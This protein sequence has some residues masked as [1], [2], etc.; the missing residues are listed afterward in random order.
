MLCDHDRVTDLEAVRLFRSSR[1]RDGSL[2]PPLEVGTV[3]MSFI[4]SVGI[5]RGGPQSLQN[6]T[7]VFPFPTDC[8]TTE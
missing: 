2:G 6:N 7:C 3:L 5:F 1:I 4:L 8:E